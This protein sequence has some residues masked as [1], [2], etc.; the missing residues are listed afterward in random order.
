V[1]GCDAAGRSDVE[2]QQAA[3]DVRQR[4]LTRSGCAVDDGIEIDRDGDC[5]GAND[6]EPEQTRPAYRGTQPAVAVGSSNHECGE[7]DSEYD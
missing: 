5:G 1:Q 6:G 2:Q 3:G 4:S 7:E